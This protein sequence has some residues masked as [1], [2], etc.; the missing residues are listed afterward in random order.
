MALRRTPGGLE[1]HLI[2]Y[3]K[4]GHELPDLEGT[5]ASDRAVEELS[6]PGRDITDVFLLSHGWQGDYVDAIAQ[7]DA[8]LDGPGP[9]RRDDAVRPFVIGVHWP[10]KAWS[11]RELRSAPSGLLEEMPAEAESTV[12][13]EEAVEDLIAELGDG[14]EVRDALETVLAYAAEIDPETQAEGTEQLPPDVVDAYRTLA[15]AVG[16]DADDPLLSGGWDPDAVFAEATSAQAEDDGGLLGVGDWLRGLRDA[17]LTPLRQLTFWHSKNH[18]REFG[19]GAVADLLRRVMGGTDARVHLIGHS[20]GTIVMAG[21]VRGPGEFPDPPPRPVDSLFLMQGAVSL[22]AFADR[23]PGQF[24]GG[25]GY[26]ADIVA[27][28]FVRGPIVA[29]R[30]RW[31]YAVGRF[32]P[33]AVGIV[34]QYLLGEELPKFGGIGAWGIQGVAGAVELPALQPGDTADP[35]LADGVVHNVDASAVISRLAGAAGAHNDV[36]HAE[37]RRLAWHAALAR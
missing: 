4:R 32:Y 21:A 25:I 9:D 19:E 23:A 27:P 24:G 35:G 28:E 37:L 13:V 31:D 8:W 22:W 17:V 6:S 14:P 29:T 30:S 18:A 16:A 26:F 20:F 15:G 12:S 5:V 1:Y 2:A 7:Y 34:G 36:A 11:D 10:S 3:D 33:L